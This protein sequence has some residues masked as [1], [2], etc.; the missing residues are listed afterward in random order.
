MRHL[1]LGLFLLTVACTQT[2]GV[3]P[4]GD[5]L[6]ITVE[7]DPYTGALSGAQRR[8]L[9]QASAYCAERRGVPDVS[10]VNSQPGQIGGFSAFTVLFRC[11]PV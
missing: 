5:D 11:R 1:L 4:A 2:T 6:L 3:M 7:T 10:R 8:A 9:E